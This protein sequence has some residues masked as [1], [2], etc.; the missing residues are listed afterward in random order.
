MSSLHRA[1]NKAT[2]K[3]PKITPYYGRKNSPWAKRKEKKN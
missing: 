1:R 3:N 2:F